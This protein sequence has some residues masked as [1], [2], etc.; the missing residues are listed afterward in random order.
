MKADFKH[1]AGA[2]IIRIVRTFHCGAPQ[3]VAGFAFGGARR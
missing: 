1:K 3:A 2:G